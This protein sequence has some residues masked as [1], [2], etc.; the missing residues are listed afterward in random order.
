MARWVQSQVVSEAAK[1]PAMVRR[2]VARP[3]PSA[4]CSGDRSESRMLRIGMK[5]NATPRPM[6]SCAI[7]MCQ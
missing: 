2:K 7:A 6:I 3:E 4:I 5:K 1:L